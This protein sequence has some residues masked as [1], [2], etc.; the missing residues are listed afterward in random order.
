MLAGKP[1]GYKE[2]VGYLTVGERGCG[3]RDVFDTIG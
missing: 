2:L 3:A 1:I